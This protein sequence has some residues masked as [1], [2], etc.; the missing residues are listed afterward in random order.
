MGLHIVLFEPEIPQNTGNIA[1]TCAALNAQLHL[2]H[3]L[4]FLLS[5]KHIRRAGLDYWHLLTIHQY[6]S[7]DSFLLEHE[8][9]ELWFFTTKGEKAYTEAVYSATNVSDL[10]QRE[11]RY[12]TGYP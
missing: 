3:P 9:D 10:W 4:G 11:R 1:R 6:P 8:K 7:I 12:S 5:E 2:V